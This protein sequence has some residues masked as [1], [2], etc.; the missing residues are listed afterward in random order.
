MWYVCG[1]LSVCNS[2]EHTHTHACTREKIVRWQHMNQEVEQ[3]VLEPCCFAQSQVSMLRVF[4]AQILPRSF[5]CLTDTHPLLS[6]C[7]HMVYIYIDVCLSSV[8]VSV[9]SEV[10][11]RHTSGASYVFFCLFGLV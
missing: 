7:I 5:L 11:F 4:S 10:N 9:R 6:L 8:H 2:H 3:R 1:P